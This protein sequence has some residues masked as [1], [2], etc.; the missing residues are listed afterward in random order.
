MDGLA[1]ERQ[2]E[3]CLQL[4]AREGWTVVEPHYVDQSISAYDMSKK[5]AAYDRMVEDYEAGLFSA[6]VCWDL[7]RLT[8]QPR[9]LGNR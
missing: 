2:R 3:D 5:R 6:I 8:R 1:I 9:Q 7:D 4:A